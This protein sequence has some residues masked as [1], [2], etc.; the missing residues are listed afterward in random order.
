MNAQR[1]N[2]IFHVNQTVTFYNGV[3]QVFATVTR[4]WHSGSG[5]SVIANGRSML[6]EHIGLGVFTYKHNRAHVLHAVV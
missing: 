4:V 2:A 3:S 6:F 1:P 5:V